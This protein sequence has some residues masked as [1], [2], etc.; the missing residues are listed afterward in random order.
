MGARELLQRLQGSGLSFRVE[1]GALLVAPVEAI[2]DEAR[3]A[4]REHRDALLRLV[5]DPDRRV[6]CASCAW[7]RGHWCGAGARS[8]LPTGF[9]GGI[10]TLP[11]HCPSWLEGRS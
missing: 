6:T 5:A 1:A 10:E 9:I 3:A 7:P 4:I 2:D 11:Q 8:G